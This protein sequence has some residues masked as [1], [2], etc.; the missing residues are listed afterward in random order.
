M[1]SEH[2]AR[3]LAPAEAPLTGRMDPR[4]SRAGLGEGRNYYISPEESQQ[5]QE[6]CLWSLDW[7]GGGE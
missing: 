2:R 6:I 5:R 3:V 4:A 7:G 1:G